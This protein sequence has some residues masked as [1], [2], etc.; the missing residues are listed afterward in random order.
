[1]DPSGLTQFEET[2]PEF[3]EIKQAN[4]ANQT[5]FDFEKH[6]ISITTDASYKSTEEYSDAFVGFDVINSLERQSENQQSPNK[7]GTTSGAHELNIAPIQAS[8][9]AYTEPQSNETIKG[10]SLLNNIYGFLF[11]DEEIVSSSSSSQATITSSTT[12]PSSTEMI[13]VHKTNKTNNSNQSSVPL[14][15]ITI[16]NNSKKEN[17]TKAEI[18]Q[19]KNN[20]IIDPTDEPLLDDS[21]LTTEA[22]TKNDFDKAENLTFLR[23]VLLASLGRPHGEISDELLHKSPLFLQRPINKLSPSFISSASFPSLTASNAVESK[24]NFQKNA[25]RSE[26]DLIIPELNKNK[27]SNDFSH[28][29]N[30]SPE[31]YQVLPTDDTHISNTESYVINP[32]DVDK[33]KEHHTQSETQIFTPPHKDPAGLLK[34]A[35]CNIYGRMYR[36]GRI[37]AELS[38]PCLECRCTEVGVSCTPL[39]C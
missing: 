29:N 9:I 26:L 20:K 1:M 17:P 13:K 4:D 28:M 32:V 14:K 19:R 27:Q 34:L 25:I 35:G 21:A 33:L 2:L 16:I 3:K 7:N 15:L 12:V 8:S 11:K 36:V 5:N 39:N 22:T 30:Y 31:N 6:I 38:S 37:I 24:Q 10:E 18:K 23:D